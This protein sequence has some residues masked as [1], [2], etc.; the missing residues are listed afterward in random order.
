MNEADIYVLDAT[1]FIESYKR[2]YAFDLAPS[3]WESLVGNAQRNQLH[4]ID[5]V[6]DEIDRQQDELKDWAN[7]E[8]LRWFESTNE[9]D[10]V[11]YYSDIVEWGTK[12]DFYTQK[13]KDT[14]ADAKRAD[15]WV[16]AFAGSRNRIV[17][18]DE[19]YDTK[20]RRKFPIP[21]I[22]ERFGVECVDTF[23]MLRRFGVRF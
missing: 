1:V 15:A 22:C 8:F 21:V 3:F 13:A 20:Q 9:V 19:R 10:I 11:D 17:V 2:H 14:L 7:R 23:E 4:S 16:I 5:K 6:K 12:Q 18:T